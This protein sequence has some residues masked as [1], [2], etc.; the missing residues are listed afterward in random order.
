MTDL[1]M[2]IGERV[3]G[4]A[5]S[6]KLFAPDMEATFPFDLDDESYVVVVKRDP[7]NLTGS[8]KS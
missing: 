3:I 4:A 5:D 6:I 8:T 7:R 1:A 2:E